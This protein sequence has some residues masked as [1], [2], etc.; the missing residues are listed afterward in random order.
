M[1]IVRHITFTIPKSWSTRT[2][3]LPVLFYCVLR[4][5]FAHIFYYLFAA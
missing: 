5:C 1:A 3:C 4:D 2:S